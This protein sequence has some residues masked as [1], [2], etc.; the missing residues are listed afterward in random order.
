MT[1]RRH[2]FHETP[3]TLEAWCIERSW[4]AYR[5]KQVLEWVIPGVAARAFVC[6][7]P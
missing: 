4:P 2:I 7:F 3:E 6:R 1:D 5:A